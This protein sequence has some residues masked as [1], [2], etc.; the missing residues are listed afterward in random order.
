MSDRPENKRSAPRYTV[1]MDAEI[2]DLL[3]RTNMKLRSS[4]ISVTGCYIDAL[5]P[6]ERGT[7]VSLRLVHD[8]QVFESK[9]VV[10]YTVARL[11][12]G[13]KTSISPFTRTNSLSSAG[14]FLRLR[15][16]LPLLRESRSKPPF[17]ADHAATVT[18]F[19][20]GSFRVRSARARSSLEASGDQ[21]CRKAGPSG[22]RAIR[23]SWMRKLRAC[24]RRS[25]SASR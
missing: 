5:N 1:I 3:T 25:F 21:R 24:S 12:M 23:S 19:V 14:G 18:S 10:A 2:T 16:T 7:P 13:V 15:M 20:P 17:R 8:S 9:G 4:D 22:G 11:G 6:L